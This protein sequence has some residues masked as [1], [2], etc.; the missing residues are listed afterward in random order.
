MAWQ[1]T[2]T[3][4]KIADFSATKNNFEHG[5]LFGKSVI[6]Y[7][8]CLEYYIRAGS[9]LKVSRHLNKAEN[10]NMMYH[11]GAI[12][13]NVIQHQTVHKSIIMNKQKDEK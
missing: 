3:F 9:T 8:F 7:F 12:T 5:G 1:A 2:V 10:L 11:S 4:A 13:P 6:T